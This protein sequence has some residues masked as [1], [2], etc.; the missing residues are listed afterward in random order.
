[1]RQKDTEDS[2]T[3]LSSVSFCRGTTQPKDISTSQDHSAFNEIAWPYLP[4]LY[5]EILFLQR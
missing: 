4:C 5:E 2:K 1:M 3:M